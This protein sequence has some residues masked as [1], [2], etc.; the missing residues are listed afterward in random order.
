MLGLCGYPTMGK[1]RGQNFLHAH[2]DFYTPRR[3]YTETG[4]PSAPIITKKVPDVDPEF[5][6]LPGE[7]S[8]LNLC[9]EAQTL[10]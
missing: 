6:N 7:P 5:P 1:S 10:H 2:T 8:G 4:A 9:P 3:S